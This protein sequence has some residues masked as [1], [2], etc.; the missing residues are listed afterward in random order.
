MVNFR[1]VFNLEQAAD[2]AGISTGLLHLWVSTGKVKPSLNMTVDATAVKDSLA[3][4]ALQ[5]TSWTN[6]DESSNWI[7]SADDVERIRSIVESTAK[8]DLSPPKK[9]TAWNPKADNGTHYTVGELASAWGLS[10]DTIRRLFE[11]EPDVMTLGNKNPRG[12]RRRVTLRIPH[13][14]AARVHK[15]LSSV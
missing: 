14:V 3:R 1:A 13:N 8:K 10:D 6:P 12:K 2:K 7:F 11:N 15:K 4:R 5:Q 9:L